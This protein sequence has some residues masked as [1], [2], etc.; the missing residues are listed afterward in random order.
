MRKNNALHTRTTQINWCERDQ[1]ESLVTS[2]IRF[3]LMRVKVH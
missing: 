1:C 3:P 2:L